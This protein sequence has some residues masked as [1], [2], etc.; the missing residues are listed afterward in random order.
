MLNLTKAFA[1]YSIDDLQ[2]AKTFY[3]DTLG[4]E[5]RELPQGLQIG[6]NLFLYVK[7]NH[8]P[9]TFTVFNFP[10]DS[11]DDT[12]AWLKSRGVKLEIYDTPDL[13]TDANGIA[14]SDGRGP[15][16]AWFKD[17]AGNF[18]SVLEPM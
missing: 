11:V 15:T 8:Q 14:R 12:V 2:K 4:L 13:K 9:A 16:I 3:A 1:S 7:P 5:V 17:P 10:V 6:S 18:I